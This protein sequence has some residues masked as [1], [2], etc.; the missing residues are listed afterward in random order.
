MKCILKSRRQLNSNLSKYEI[1]GSQFIPGNTRTISNIK[2]SNNDKYI[3][4]GSWDGSINL[5]NNQDLS[6]FKKLHQVSIMKNIRIKLE[7]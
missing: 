3:A 5:L 1:Y 2:I 7:Q 4:C 6:I